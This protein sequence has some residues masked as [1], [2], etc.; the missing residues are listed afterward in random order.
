M[1]RFLAFLLC[2]LCL[3]MLPAR[4]ATYTYLR[5]EW[6]DT[7]RD[8]YGVALLQLAFAKAHACHALVYSAEPMKQGRA[9]YELEHGTGALDIMITMTSAERESKLLAVPIPLT[10]GVLGWRIPLVRK[11]RLQMFADVRTVEQMKSFVAGQGH[12]WPDVGILRA[13]GLP[14]HV[15]SAY[16]GMFKML[17]ANRI[18]YFP[19]AVQQVFD[20][21]G[22]Y[23]GLA[24][25]PNLVLRYP[26]DAYFFVNRSNVVL[27]GDPPRPRGGR[28]RRFLR[29]PV[30]QLFRVEDR[31][32]RPRA[33]ACGGPAESPA[34]AAAGAQ[35]PVV[36]A[37]RNAAPGLQSRVEARR[38]RGAAALRAG[39]TALT[40]AA[41]VQYAI[42][43]S[44]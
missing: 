40:A 43:R 25:E 5:P 15:S 3:G 10:K 6:S 1:R 35:V 33:A 22:R 26:T 21:V 24:V 23:P 36:F 42:W 39:G 4:A 13:S 2:V 31:G 17:E 16:D 34:V 38:V 41:S 8:P 44:R 30:L 37:R 14:V 28:R 20:E 29:P 7:G 27:A 32:R 9:I 12:D 19:R 11:E 18:D